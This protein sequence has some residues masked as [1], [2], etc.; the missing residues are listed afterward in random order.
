M[1]SRDKKILSPREVRLER[2]R[3]NYQEHL[4]KVAKGIIANAIEETIYG[5]RDYVETDDSKIIITLYL[6][7]CRENSSNESEEEQKTLKV[8]KNKSFPEAELIMWLEDAGWEYEK[9]SSDE[10]TSYYIIE[11]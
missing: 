9:Y 3:L 1:L 2:K 11:K 4:L 7:D 10:L 6:K 5:K 8:L